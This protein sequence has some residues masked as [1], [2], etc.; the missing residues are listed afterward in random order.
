MAAHGSAAESPG[1]V[2]KLAIGASIW[3][4]RWGKNAGPTAI[5]RASRNSLRAK[6]RAH[7]WSVRNAQ[8]I[9]PQGNSARNVEL[10]SRSSV[11]TGCGGEGRAE[12]EVLP[13]LRPV[14]ECAAA[15]C[16]AIWRLIAHFQKLRK[17]E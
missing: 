17:L 8:H 13:R 6:C 15:R 16:N 4:R 14:D 1:S 10:R 5:R 11:C 2:H 9:G 12:R 3:A 7:K